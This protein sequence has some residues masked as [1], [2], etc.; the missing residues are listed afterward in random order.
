MKNTSPLTQP[1]KV[2]SISRRFSYAF[3]GVVTL[4][5]L[6]FA[7][8]AGFVSSAR[9]SADL[10][11]RADHALQLA[12][13]SLPIAV[14][15]GDI[16]VVD[17]IA[18]AIMADDAIVYLTVR[19]QN[20]VIFR[21]A[22][23][24]FWDK[25]YAYFNTSAQFIVKQKQLYF[26]DITTKNEYVGSITLVV[27]REGV[28]NEVISNIFGIVALTISI[29]A[30]IS[31]T[32]AFITRRYISRP[33]SKLQNSAALIAGGG[34]EAPIDKS[35]RDEIGSLA[36][37]LDT[38]R[39]AIKDAREN[40]EHKVEARTRDLTE[41]LEQQTAISDVLKVMSGSTFELQPVLKTL[42]EN[43]TKLCGADKGMI[44]RSDGDVYRLAVTYGGAPPKW[45]EFLEK[46]PISPG[47][48]TVVG[49]VAL[50]RR[51]I[52]IGDV[53]A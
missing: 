22:R 11:R 50:E 12:A 13:I 14:W 29:I 10:E 36:Q 6:A 39:G 9:I 7:V 1:P 38:M 48:G 19:E 32:S 41:A 49:R 18:K 37:D 21:D 25:D 35:S 8:V 51:I 46:N 4:L 40:L 20:I 17:D 27:S 44:F 28:R 23:K 30:A 53:L 45:I 52:H 47:R 34:L 43:A 33:L 24:E 16:L 2:R 26:S 31:L 3:I 42:I 5:L 15:K